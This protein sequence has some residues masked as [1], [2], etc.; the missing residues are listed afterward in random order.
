M[1]NVHSLRVVRADRPDP[2]PPEMLDDILDAGRWTGSSKNRQAWA[3]VVIDDPE[4]LEA[5]ATAGHSTDPIRR[6]AVSIALV[7]TA[8]GNDFDIGRLAQNLMLAAASH[9]VGSCPIT[10]HDTE[11]SRE[12]LGLPADAE[13]RYA[14]AFGFPDEERDAESRADRRARGMA[15]R[16]SPD[17]FARR[18]GWGK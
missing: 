18:G 12:V 8:E 17:E 2:I 9:G 4:G 11:R 10:L 7:K 16:M 6:S 1:E 3:A 13:C 15:G 14:I 5:L